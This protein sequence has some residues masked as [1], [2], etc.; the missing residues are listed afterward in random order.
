MEDLMQ[1]LH[2]AIEGGLSTEVAP[3][4]PGGVA[5]MLEL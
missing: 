2:E 5:R 1:N 4:E 3:S